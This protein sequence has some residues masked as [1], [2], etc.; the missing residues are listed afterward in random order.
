MNNVKFRTK[1]E[2]IIFVLLNIVC[3]DFLQT[4]LVGMIG[5]SFLGIM[6]HRFFLPEYDIYSPSSAFDY[7]LFALFL[8]FLFF[9]ILI[10][11][12]CL[13][14]VYSYY[15]HNAK[16][17]TLVLFIKRFKERISWQFIFVAL[18]CLI[19]LLL[20]LFNSLLP[21]ILQ[22]PMAELGLQLWDVLIGPV[23]ILAVLWISKLGFIKNWVTALS[24]TDEK[25]K[26]WDFYRKVLFAVVIIYWLAV[27]LVLLG[28]L[29]DI[30]YF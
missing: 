5:V 1:L 15:E 25:R 23:I 3:I 6:V 9:Y 19:V 24:N 18:L 27:Y 7:T 4:A 2:W 14:I 8:I 28:L 16:S 12:S 22:I 11:I 26:K 21:M 10:R 17:E 20:R 30:I 13:A 29:F